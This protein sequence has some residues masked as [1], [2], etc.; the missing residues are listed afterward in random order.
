MAKKRTPLWGVG[1]NDSNYTL[2][3]REKSENGK[4]RL[5]WVC[6]YYDKWRSMIQ[7]CYSPSNLKR[8]PTYIGCEVCEDWKIFSKFKSWMEEQQW[9]GMQLDKDIIFL[10]N[11]LYSPRTCAFV[12]KRANT[13]VRDTSKR[14][15]LLKEGVSMSKNSD[16]YFAFCRNPFSKGSN[17]LGAFNSEDDAHN[18][19]L[20]KKQE[21][22]KQLAKGEVDTR[23]IDALC[24]FKS[25]YLSYHNTQYKS[26]ELG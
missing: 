10:G 22:A 5:K 11:K 17:Y 12:T 4:K 6:P 18:A 23:V 9:E 1:V 20:D 2:E 19:W 7:R 8:N 25:N 24:N 26:A 16:K 15:G 13:F 14:R 21:F 3:I